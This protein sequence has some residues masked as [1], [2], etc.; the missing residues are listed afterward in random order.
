MLKTNLNDCTTFILISRSCFIWILWAVFFSLSHSI[1]AQKIGIYS[2]VMLGDAA[3]IALHNSNVHFFEGLILTTLDNQGKVHFFSPS[4]G[5]ETHHESHVD[6]KV[7]SNGHESFIF[8][9][10]NKGIYQP[11]GIVHSNLYELSVRFHFS[12]PP[13]AK[14]LGQLNQISP[15]FY[16]ET[17]GETQAILKLSWN[18]F[19]QL[20]TWVEDIDAL[21]LVGYTGEHWEIIPALLSPFSITG[22]QP[23]SL[24]EGAIFS[25]NEVD[26]S[27]YSAFSLGSVLIEIDLFIS[28]A[29]TANGDGIND[30]WYIK[31]IEYYP[32]ASIAVF[33]RWGARVF[34]QASNYQNDWSGNFDNNSKP[35][36]SA[37]YFYRIDLDNDGEIDHEGWIYINH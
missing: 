27:R 29:I 13:K 23:S 3:T 4:Q 28:Q 34:A 9:V 2:D 6:A 37:P 30:V 35:L 25:S 36:P 18:N 12:A 20:E 22:N 1:Q 15:N 5:K 8:P 11:L 7:S 32:E 19:S 33:N 21:R 16:W 24:T 31:N 26:L 10:G 17:E 14:F